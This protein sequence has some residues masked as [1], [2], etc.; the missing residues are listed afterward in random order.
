MPDDRLEILGALDDPA[1]DLPPDT[2]DARSEER[3]PLHELV[4]KRRDDAGI[5]SAQA[6]TSASWSSRL[7]ASAPAAPCATNPFPD[8]DG[9]RLLLLKST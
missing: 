8:G 9:L 5:D 1:A 6:G 7:S 4:A 3:A 2:L